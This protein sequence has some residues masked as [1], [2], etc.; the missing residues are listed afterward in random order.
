MSTHRDAEIADVV[1]VLSTGCEGKVDEALESLR[2][3]GLDVSESDMDN[4][5]VAGTIDAAKLPA[6]RSMGCV[7]YV[8]VSMTYIADYPPGDPRNHDAT[9]ADAADMDDDDEVDGAETVWS[10]LPS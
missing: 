3:A 6:L 1:V 8:R 9:P 7:N 2:G 10:P 4:L 5:T